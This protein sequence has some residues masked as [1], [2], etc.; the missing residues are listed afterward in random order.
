MPRFVIKN[1]ELVE[2]AKRYHDSYVA[3]EKLLKDLKVAMETV[4]SQWKD[5]IA[6]VW[7]DLTPQTVTDLEKIS[8]NLSYNNNLLTDVANKVSDLQ[9]TIKSEISKLYL[10]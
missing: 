2:A 6:D 1:K 10:K 7:E 5:E 3:Y 8:T 4:T 9:N